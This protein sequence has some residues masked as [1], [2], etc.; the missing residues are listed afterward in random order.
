MPGGFEH[1]RVAG[2][3]L[4]RKRAVELDVCQ[5]DGHPGEEAGDGGEV[6]EPGEDCGGAGGAGEVGEE[7]DGGCEED[8]VV[9]YASGRNGVSIFGSLS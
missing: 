7:G 2:Y 6:L 8:A 9:G 4:R 5:A 3:A 1:E